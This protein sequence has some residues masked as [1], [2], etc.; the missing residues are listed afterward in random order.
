MSDAVTTAWL[1][2]R[3]STVWRKKGLKV[4]DE[5]AFVP[6]TWTH[7]FNQTIVA[8]FVSIIDIVKTYRKAV[9]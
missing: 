6:L 7:F 1:N 8:Y 2:L 5:N 4:C 9:I 3:L